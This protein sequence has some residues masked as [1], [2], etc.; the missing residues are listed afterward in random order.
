MAQVTH[1]DLSILEADPA[2]RALLGHLHQERLQLIELLAYG[3]LN[4]DRDREQAR[5]K[6]IQIDAVLKWTDDKRKELKKQELQEQLHK[7]RH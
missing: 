4:S 7:G 2:F 3:N 6:L 1:Q 5:G